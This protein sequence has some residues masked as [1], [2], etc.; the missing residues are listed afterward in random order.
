MK[1]Y[2]YNV[3]ILKNNCL[4]E[5]PEQIIDFYKKNIEFQQLV[6]LINNVK[7]RKMDSVLT[8]DSSEKTSAVKDQLSGLHLITQ[9]LSENEK[10]WINVAFAR[11]YGIKGIRMLKGKEETGLTKTSN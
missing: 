10:T 11:Y 3:E 8:I 4:R 2:N 1:K 9:E 7:S 6:I 5:I